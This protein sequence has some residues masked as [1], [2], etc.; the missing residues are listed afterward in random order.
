VDEERALS[1]SRRKTGKLQV[2][3]EAKNQEK[4]R[5]GEGERG[6]LVVPRLE[7]FDE[8]VR[9]LFPFVFRLE[10]VHKDRNVKASRP[11]LLRL[12]NI[13]RHLPQ[14]AQDPGNIIPLV[15]DGS[16]TAEGIP[17]RV[18]ILLPADTKASQRDAAFNVLREAT[19]IFDFVD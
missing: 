2:L 5:I 15:L 1:E 17:L 18:N 10:R 11:T 6:H 16:F 9:R 4:M 8:R 13:A 3:P 12:D 14:G 19:D 7:E